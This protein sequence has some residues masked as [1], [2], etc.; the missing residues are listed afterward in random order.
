[1]KQPDKKKLEKAVKGMEAKAKELGWSPATSP[2]ESR[3]AID[4]P[5]FVSV[6]LEEAWGPWKRGKKGNQGG[7]ILAW[8]AEKVGFG[9]ITFCLKD[10]V[11]V[12]STECMPKVFVRRAL[13]H[14]LAT[15]VS[16]VD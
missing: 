10:G 4:E 2:E 6:K 9:Q 14:F 13:E 5:V 8:Q 16:Y 7:F 12:C 11:A 15:N 1:M 3:A